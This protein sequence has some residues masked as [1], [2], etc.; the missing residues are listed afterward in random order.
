MVEP[1]ILVR[2]GLPQRRS[3]RAG[4]S[5]TLLGNLPSIHSRKQ[6]EVRGIVFTCLGKDY[7]YVVANGITKLS[8]RDIH[9]PANRKVIKKT[10][11]VGAES[12]VLK[13][14][15]DAMPSRRNRRTLLRASHSGLDHGGEVTILCDEGDG[16][17]IGAMRGRQWQN[18]R[19]LS[20]YLPEIGEF[21]K[22]VSL[23][24]NKI[25]GIIDF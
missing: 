10:Q 4:S 23:T 5:K 25:T 2:A 16:S 18:N 21:F 12:V 11:K 6:R 22:V 7:I 19:P 9:T 3:V 15:L 17:G 24:Q 20:Y 8:W 1:R 13:Y 14:A